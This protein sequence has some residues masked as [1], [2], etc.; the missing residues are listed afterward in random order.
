[1]PNH[2]WSGAP[3]TAAPVTTTTTA[4]GAGGAS[5][6]RGDRT[7]AKETETETQTIS[8]AIGFSSNPRDSYPS[9]DKENDMW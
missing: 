9:S 3:T 8:I 5:T 2:D 4:P 7:F 6:A 1:M